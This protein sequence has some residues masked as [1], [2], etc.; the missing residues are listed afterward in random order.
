MEME[1]V[2]CATPPVLE[3]CYIGCAVLNNFRGHA[4]VEIHL[5]RSGATDA[6]L[7]SL[8]RKDLVGPPDPA[9]PPEA[10]AGAT[11]EAALRSILE[12]FTYEE[13]QKLAQWLEKRYGAQIRKLILCPMDFPV[14]LGVGPLASYPQTRNS[15][16]INFDEA[17]N[18]DLP[19]AVK[20]YYELT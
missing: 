16:F 5:F 14:P 6:E 15:G 7:A 4:N 12:C 13:C 18:Y 11:E 8:Q 19:F 2:P 20:A 10:L 9:A 17:K 3:R 1:I